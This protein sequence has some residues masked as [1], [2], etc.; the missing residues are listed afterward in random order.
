M[1]CPMSKV[2][3]VGN[4]K[5]G[6][7]KSLL[8][9]NIAVVLS[10]AKEKG[11]V[12]VL[13]IDGDVQASATMFSDMR[14]E[15]IGPDL[16]YDCVSIR[17]PAIRNQM[18]SLVEKYDHVIV[19]CGGRDNPSLRAAVTVA[20]R[21]IIPVPPRSV[22]EWALASMV[23]LVQEARSLINPN[24]KSH[25]LINMGDPQGNDNEAV[26]AA[27]EADYLTRPYDLDDPEAWTD[28]N[29]SILDPVV[30][31]R[32]PF[33]DAFGAGLS[34]VEHRP[35]D[36]KAIDELLQV[37]RVVYT[38]DSKGR[39]NG[40]SIKSKNTPQAKASRRLGSGELHRRSA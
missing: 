17:G 5:G 13:L 22:D 24:L 28:P 19:D 27:I 30:V 26:K 36:Q 6:V 25:V 34:I 18:K 38:K 12:R 7:G 16:G 40:H 23:D 4:G 1:E 14:A 10:L 37:M 11:P 33:A 39:S 8:A 32:K 20:D 29:I 2:T 15:T 9:C 35:V 21:L 3:V 31:K